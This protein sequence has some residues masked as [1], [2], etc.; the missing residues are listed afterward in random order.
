MK[1]N[2]L[3]TGVTG[4]IGSNLVKA[5]AND[6]NCFGVVRRTS[7]IEK[8]KDFCQLVYVDEIEKC[9]KNNKIDSVI[10]LAT[11]LS[12]IDK[13]N[14]YT[15]Q[16][17]SNLCFPV[18]LLELMEKFEVRNI[19]NTSTYFQFYYGNESYSPNSFYAA[20]KQA[21][22][23]L[24]KY[25]TDRLNLN[26]ID[27]LLYDVYGPNDN[28]NKVFTLI[29]NLHNN[30]DFNC[31]F[32]EQEI[33]FVFISDVIDAYRVAI[34]CLL[35]SKLTAYNLY[36]VD[37]D[38]VLLKNAIEMA[39]RVFKKS[40]KINYGLIDYN[41]ATVFKPYVFSRIENWQ[42]KITLE[43]GLKMCL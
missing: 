16:I 11:N 20:T 25:F 4:Y 1:K 13:D 26:C 2:I 3:I 35:S 30:E 32:G 18:L 8:V 10:H 41:I 42:P 21:F 5:I 14:S 19:I 31:T 24:I 43:D 36:S 27:L 17:D 29:K 12:K 37:G 22:S 15:A 7:H 33:I 40:S 28:R 34:D 39:M 23:D 6:Y 9:F 38:K